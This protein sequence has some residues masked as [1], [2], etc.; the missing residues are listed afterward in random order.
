MQKR[1]TRFATSN[2][3]GND[4]GRAGRAR[5]RSDMRRYG[6]FGVG[7]IRI[8]LRQRFH[9]KDIKR[10][11]RQFFTVQRCQNGPIIDQRPPARIDQNR[12]IRQQ[13]NPSTLGHGT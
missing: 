10:G 3:L 13:R 9:P 6:D 8:V 11:M 5:G 4:A 7:P 1:L 2:I 12:A